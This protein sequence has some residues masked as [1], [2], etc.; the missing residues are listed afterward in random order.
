M[1]STAI[2]SSLSLA[3]ATLKY[4]F[5][6]VINRI[7]I[8]FGLSILFFISGCSSLGPDFLKPEAKVAT[9]WLTDGEVFSNDTAF[10][11]RWWETFNDPVLNLVVTTHTTSE[12][13]AI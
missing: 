11:E 6:F 12:I 4:P 13:S 7:L 3:N 9:D 1:I 2:R 8:G 10:Q 5:Y